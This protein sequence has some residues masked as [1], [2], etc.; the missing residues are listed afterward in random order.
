MADE[1]QKKKMLNLGKLFKDVI[2]SNIREWMDI[3]CMLLHVTY[4][5]QSK[6]ILYSL[7]ECQGT[8]C[9]KQATYLK[10]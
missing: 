7:P 10:Y 2:E 6:S 9:S 4:E 5:F 8:P 3:V 1:V